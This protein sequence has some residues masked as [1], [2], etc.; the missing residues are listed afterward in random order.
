MRKLALTAIILTAL[1]AHGA[2]NAQNSGGGLAP[3]LSKPTPG[4]L[5]NQDYLTPTGETVPR[6]GV[7]QAPGPSPLDH[8]LEQQDNRIDK[9]ICSNC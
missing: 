6:P 3:E 2:A 4:H 5:L 7:S 8:T 9:S 1:M